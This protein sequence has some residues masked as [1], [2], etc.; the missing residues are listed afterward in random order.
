VTLID[1]RPLAAAIRARSAAE[2]A[3][4][5]LD[6]VV[7][8][9]ATVV[10]TADEATRWYLRSIVKAAAAAGI[11]MRE[12]ELDPHDGQGVLDA[13]DRLSADESV[14]GIICLTPLPDGLT[15]ATAG[16]QVHPAK[17][18]DGANPL[19]LGRLLVGLPAFAPATAQAVIEILRATPTA[20]AGTEAV[21][22][23][24]SIVV[25]KPLTLLLLAEHATV[26]VCHSH[27]RDLAAVTRR[28]EVLVAAAGQARLI[29][30]EH[31]RE[32]AVVIDVG[33]NPTEEGGLV[34]DVD[35]HAVEAVARA[36]T[37]VPG[38]VGPV[39]TALLLANVVEA[40]RRAVS[41]RD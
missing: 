37:P 16:A 40:A 28:A 9:L 23:G 38:G 39:T 1:G 14:H 26:T 7:P 41:R 2:I 11:A 10:A 24:R 5:T 36:V 3:A 17:D 12:L 20:L 22:V 33:T 4:L 15:L 32:G 34:G 6:G 13:L 31:V 25:G 30:A 21:V 19:S 8:T 27:T 35:T 18:V 29:G